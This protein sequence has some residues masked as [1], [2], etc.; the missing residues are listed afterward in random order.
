MLL[1]STKNQSSELR[2]ISV[3]C[4]DVHRLEP[5]YWLFF[6][7]RKIIVIIIII[8]IFF[9]GKDIENSS[10]WIVSICY[11]IYCVFLKV[12]SVFHLQY[13]FNS[14]YSFKVSVK[15]V[16]KCVFWPRLSYVFFPN[17]TYSCVEKYHKHQLSF[18]G[19]LMNNFTITV[20]QN[21]KN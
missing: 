21:I 3:V 6:L 20:G 19:S 8:T 11:I 5:R 10:C 7:A 13:L 17:C 12:C 18:L 14:D 1:S 16:C 2:R 9:C 15:Y 4:L